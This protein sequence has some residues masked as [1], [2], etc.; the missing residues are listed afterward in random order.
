[1]GK[2]KTH[3]SLHHVGIRACSLKGYVSLGTCMCLR[4]C[5]EYSGRNIN[6]DVSYLEERSLETCI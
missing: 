3:N 6:N 1:M 5:R 2:R 4:L